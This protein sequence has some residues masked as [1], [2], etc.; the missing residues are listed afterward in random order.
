M[1]PSISVE[2]SGA[3]SV[4]TARGKIAAGDSSMAFQSALEHLLGGG[5]R[6]ILLD[7]EQVTYMDSAGLGQLAAAFGSVRQAGGE[8]KLLRVNP[9]IKAL[10]HI[11]RL[12][13]VFEIF[14]ARDAALRSASGSPGSTMLTTRLAGRSSKP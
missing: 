2:Q 6:F 8:L 4:L 9:R 5:C 11:T 1:Q 13:H 14:S 3:V 10:L 7:L 12:N